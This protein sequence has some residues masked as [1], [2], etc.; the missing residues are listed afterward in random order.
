M[1]R[2]D[3]KGP[4][5]CGEIDRLITEV[6]SITLVA[7]AACSKHMA[8]PRY[9]ASG[10]LKPNPDQTERLLVMS[11]VFSFVKKN[12]GLDA[13]R[14][15]LIGSSIDNDAD[16]ATSPIEAICD[17]RYDEVRASAQQLIDGIPYSA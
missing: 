8:C 6:G 12:E 2:L 11:E 3:E 17:G 15:W 5:N 1:A 4:L 16:E 14:Q 7:L 13:A 10:M 9:W